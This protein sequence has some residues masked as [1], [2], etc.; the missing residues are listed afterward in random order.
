MERLFDQIIEDYRR[1]IFVK[2]TRKTYILK[3]IYLVNI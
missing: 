2:I 3:K 1:F